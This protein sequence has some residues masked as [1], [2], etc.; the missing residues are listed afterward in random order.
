MKYEEKEQS[1]AAD[2]NQLTGRV[3]ANPQGEKK[4]ATTITHQQQQQ[5]YLAA[6][7]AA[8]PFVV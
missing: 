5:K 2:H 7:T 6:G 1:V 8:V 4:T 3:I